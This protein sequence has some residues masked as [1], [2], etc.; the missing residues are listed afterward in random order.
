MTLQEVQINALRPAFSCFADDHAAA[1][2][3]RCWSSWNKLCIFLVQA[4]LIE[5]NPMLMIEPPEREKLLPKSLETNVIDALFAALAAENSPNNRRRA[6]DW[7][8]RDRALILTGLLAGMRLDEMVRFN[9]GD[10]RRTEGGG[11]ILAVRGKGDKERRVPVE[12]PLVEVLQ[13]YLVSRAYRLP[14]ARRRLAAEDVF[15]AWSPKDP[16][17]V[18]VDDQRITRDTLQYRVLRIFRK[19]GIDGQRAR[20]ALVHGLRHTYAT[21]L[22]ESNVSVYELM[23]LLGHSSIATSQRYVTAAGAVNRAAAARNP[24]YQRL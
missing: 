17:F 20:G 4:G 19:A 7:P 15:V 13:D 21:Q 10:L 8:E 16:M 14:P 12:A 18:G 2:V 5:L 24:L 1:S 6:S 3:R 11:A 9:M 22:A 23:H